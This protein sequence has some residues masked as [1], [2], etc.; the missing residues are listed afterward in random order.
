MDLAGLVPHRDLDVEVV[1]SQAR[2]RCDH[3]GRATGEDLGD[4]ARADAVHDLG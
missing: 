4:A 2:D 3:S 1:A